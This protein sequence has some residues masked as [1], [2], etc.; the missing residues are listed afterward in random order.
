MMFWYGM[1]NFFLVG[2]WF[3]VGLLFSF[4]NA[5][6]PVKVDIVEKTAI[7]EGLPV[8]KPLFQGGCHTK[9]RMAYVLQKSDTCGCRCLKSG[10]DMGADTILS[11]TIIAWAFLPVNRN[12]VP[13]CVICAPV[14]CHF[15][16]FVL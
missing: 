5:L 14:W 12:A 10:M 1:R 4:F 8:S 7:P 9:E 16:V 15:F 2:S 13:V 3:P 11:M 6:P